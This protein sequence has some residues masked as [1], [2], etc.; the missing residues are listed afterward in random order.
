MEF[1]DHFTLTLIHT[2]GSGELMH[3]RSQIAENSNFVRESKDHL[4]RTSIDP[5][6]AL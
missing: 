3:F 5:N 6:L 1:T 4:A 2:S